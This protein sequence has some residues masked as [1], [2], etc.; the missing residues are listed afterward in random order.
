MVSILSRLLPA[1]A[2]TVLSQFVRFGAVGLVGLGVDIAVVYGTRA[3]LG[4]YAAGLLAYVAAATVNWWLNR[5]W[6]FRDHTNGMFRQWLAF[7]SANAVGFVWNRGTYALLVTFSPL[8]IQ[9]PV[10]AVAAGVPVAMIFNFYLSR[11]VVFR[12]PQQ[13]ND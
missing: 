6:T 4:L 12:S 7:M 2:A 9:Y 10:I 11:R 13:P 5:I 8:C 3:P 1:K